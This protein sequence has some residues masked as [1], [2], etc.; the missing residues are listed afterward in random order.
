M[1]IFFLNDINKSIYRNVK[2][3]EDT[4]IEIDKKRY[5]NHL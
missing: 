5:T 1:I 2:T 4:K 3:G